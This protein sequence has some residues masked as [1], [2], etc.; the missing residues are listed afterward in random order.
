[1]CDRT[2]KGIAVTCRRNM[3][4]VNTRISGFA[5]QAVANRTFSAQQ[6]R[7]VNLAM[8]VLPELVFGRSD[9]YGAPWTRAGTEQGILNISL[10]DVTSLYQRWPS[11]GPM[12]LLAVGP[13]SEEKLLA[14]TTDAFSELF[15]HRK[16]SHIVL[17]S[18]FTSLTR[19]RIVVA[20]RP[21]SP[22]TAIFAFT[23]CRC[24]FG[25]AFSSRLNLTLRDARQWTYGV[26]TNLLLGGNRACGSLTRRFELM[27]LPQQCKRLKTF[28][29]AW[30]ASDCPRFRAPSRKIL[31]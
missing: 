16:L 27:R 15:Q 5:D 23:S 17:P 19:S 28:G 12:E 25:G 8:R 2:A 14:L 11:S 20:S 7:P 4:L 1:M 13:A 30:L 21:R 31:Y 10:E 18:V 6:S 3:R 26:H 29:V 24:D 22:Q 9:G